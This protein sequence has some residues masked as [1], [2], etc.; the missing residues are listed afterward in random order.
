MPFASSLKIDS[1]S[2][3]LSLSLFAF[4]CSDFSTVI[5]GEVFFFQLNIDFAS[6]HFN[7]SDKARSNDAAGMETKLTWRGHYKIEPENDLCFDFSF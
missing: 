2:I 6:F 3:S 7:A 1:L 4:L 5:V